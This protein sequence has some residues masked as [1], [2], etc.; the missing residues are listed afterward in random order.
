MGRRLPSFSP[1]LGGLV[2]CLA[3]ALWGPGQTAQAAGYLEGLYLSPHPQ[4]EQAPVERA[5]I[6]RRDRN[7]YLFLPACWQGQP[8]YVHTP[9]GKAVP[10]TIQAGAGTPI[11]LAG[12]SQA[13]QPG[14][15]VTLR[16]Q[17]GK[18]LA[19]PKVLMGSGI[20]CL[21]IQTES[22][23][24]KGIHGNKALREPG[25]L[26]MYDADGSLRYQ[27]ALTEMK[28][29]GNTTFGYGKKPYQIKLAKKTDL[30][31]DGAAKTWILLADFLDSSLLRNRITLD[32]A[33]YVGM[34]YAL[35]SQ[36][37]DLYVNGNYLGVYLLAEKAQIH[38]SRVDI[39]D[40][41]PEMA[42]LNSQPLDS[43]PT[44]TQALEDG[45]EIT[46]Y[47]LE[48][49]PTDI[50]GGYLLEID[51]AYRVEMEKGTLFTPRGL[52]IL[53]CEPS[54]PSKAQMEY[55]AGVV[56]AFDRAIRQEGGI[57]PITGKHYGDVMDVQSLAE[58]FLLEEISMNYDAKAG[59]QY[60][61]K[62]MD[63]V[64]TKLYAGPGWD[65]DLTYDS[66]LHIAA[67]APYLPEMK[68]SYGWY[69]VLYQRQADFRQK[70][71]EVF[72]AQYRP[73]LEILT[74]QRPSDQPEVLK[75]LAE[76]GQEIQS[77]A[78]MNALV[79][80]PSALKSHGRY[81]NKSFDQ[82]QSQ[83]QR[84]LEQRLAGLQKAL[85]DGLGE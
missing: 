85:V 29:R 63:A 10:A 8:L 50:T 61:Y 79:W 22:G 20:P 53:V 35:A 27:G 24:L 3:L 33:R 66:V 77:S 9:Q 45:N 62:D 36:S 21:F 44:F 55:I 83:L 56:G 17:G 41:E 34:R 31:G 26:V 71:G 84:F 48:E 39:R 51:K 19:K 70:V 65:Y 1:W 42:F 38:E 23:S 28:G 5:S 2:L 76:Y 82:Q 47:L 13:F 43:Y 32:M 7:Q 52:G 15:T 58:K 67:A 46:G 25:T 57:D 68:V 72:A 60:F 75:A 37:V 16:S 12:A 18:I 74:G 4:E 80:P 30:L 78:A 81:L 11:P 14:T 40:M 69:N 6:F 49:N 59:S 54:T 73:A 64:D